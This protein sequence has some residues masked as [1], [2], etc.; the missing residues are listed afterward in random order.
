MGLISRTLRWT[1]RQR[2]PAPWFDWERIRPVSSQFGMDRGTAIDRYYIEGFLQ[3]NRH[4]IKGR[5]LEVASDE[6][7]RRYGSGAVDHFEVLHRDSQSPKAT[8]VGDLTEYRALP[9]NHVDCFIC[10][11]TFNVIFDVKEAIVGSHH[12]LKPDG[13]L[14]AT[15]AGL[16]QISRYDMDRWG[17]YWRFTTASVQKLFEPIFEEV[18]IKSYGN[19][20]AATA[21]LQGIAVEELPARSLLEETDPDYQIVISI[22]ARKKHS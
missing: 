21:L 18:E 8:I 5:T 1:K 10:T 7:S 13:V 22:V 9:P 16:C 6:Y 19:V 12:I 4:H 20:L 2:N 14:L 17:D 11:Q 3:N 15:V